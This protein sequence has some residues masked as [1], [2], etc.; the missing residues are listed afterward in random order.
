[1]W[2]IITKFTRTILKT[3]LIYA[4][5][6]NLFRSL[7]NWQIKIELILNDRLKDLSTERDIWSVCISFSENMTHTG[8]IITD[9][10]VKLKSE[11]EK[12]SVDD[13]SKHN[14]LSESKHWRLQF[15]RK[16]RHVSRGLVLKAR[17]SFERNFNIRPCYN[18]E[19]HDHGR[20]I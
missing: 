20:K 1:M 16:H 10:R 15:R 8:T 6:K 19:R 17:P 13:E 9:K 11:T 2:L 5:Y 14:L 3:K 4:L 18:C 7:T 12:Q